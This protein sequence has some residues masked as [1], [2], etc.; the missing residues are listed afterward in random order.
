MNKT[1]GC[2]IANFATVP[3]KLHM[4]IERKPWSLAANGGEVVKANKFTRFMGTS[5]TNMSGGSRKFVSSQRQDAAFIKRFLIVEMERPSEVALTN[6]LLK[7]YNNLPMLVIEKFVSVA[8]AVNNT[9]TDDSVMDI[10]QLVA[11]VG[12]SMTL[13][14]MS[15]LDTFKIAFASAL[16]AHATGMV[17]EAIDLILGDD[18]NRTMEYYT[19]KK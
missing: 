17:L 19:A 18:K 13:K 16:P 6:V 8:V 10:R 11:W 7:R 12:T 4:P 14:T 5:N 2:L 1:K 15:L 3:A 9:G